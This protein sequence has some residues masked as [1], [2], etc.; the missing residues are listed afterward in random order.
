VDVTQVMPTLFTQQFPVT[1]VGELP[2][3]TSNSPAL[4]ETMREVSSAEGPLREEWT[5][6]GLVP[7]GWAI[8]SSSALTTK[9]PIATVADLKGKRIRGNDRQS[10][11]LKAAGANVINM[12]LAEV[13][14]SLQRGLINGVYGVPFGF[15]GPLKY[16]EVAKNFTDT[17]MGA[18]S[19][20]A[21]AV[22]EKLWG[23]LSDEQKKVI[24]EVNLEVPAKVGEMDAKFDAESCEVV[25]QEDGKLFVFSDAEIAKL[26][27][28]GYQQVLD[29]WKKNIADKGVDADT[30]HTDYQAKLQ[31]A[32]GK[33]PDYR[34]GVAS[35]AE[36]LAR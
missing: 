5:A 24:E 17:G 28:A 11:V 2:F 14:G 20:N 4:S 29:E 36:T 23:E 7:L 31:A 10:R 22:S 35:C 16:A 12:E 13:Y 27:A 9:D 19:V 30:F 34:T 21:L 15:I 1:A 18:A 3:E 26:K 33:F 25:K 8:G 32:E 6:Q